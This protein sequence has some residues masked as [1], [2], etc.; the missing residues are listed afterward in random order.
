[1]ASAT[2]EAKIVLILSWSEAATLERLL[3]RQ[4]FP[5]DETADDERV[6]AIWSELDN[7]LPAQAEEV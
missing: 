3:I 7:A 6:G 5:E 1:M 2:K 4:E